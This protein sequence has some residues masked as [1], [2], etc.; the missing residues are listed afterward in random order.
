MYERI[1]VPLDGSALSEA[2]LP[3]AEAIGE[4]FASTLILLQVVASPPE[5]GS[6]VPA[7]TFAVT[8]KED[9]AD[10]EQ[11]LATITERLRSAPLKTE[12]RVVVGD[13]ADE[14]LATAAA[15]NASLIV[16]ATHGR[17]GLGRAIS[18]SAASE[19]LQ[20][21]HRPLLLIHPE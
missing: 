3:H 13:A 4:Q 9:R 6:D 7:G 19:V 20:R 17:G 11:Y 1:L 10:A 21:C 14:I 16:M 8:A 5:T 15:D 12:G 18:G 2:A